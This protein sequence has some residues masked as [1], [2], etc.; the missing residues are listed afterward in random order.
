MRQPTIGIPVNNVTTETHSHTTWHPGERSMQAMAGMRERMDVI[1][2][3]ALRDFLPQQHRDFYAQLPFMVAG[4][5]DTADNPWATLLFGEPGFVSSPDA[6][7]LTLR[8]ATNTL[9]PATQHLRADSPIG[10][11]GIE[12]PTRRR[13]RVNGRL[14]HRDATGFG[15]QVEQTMGNC[16][17]YIQKRD[18]S[19]TPMANRPSAQTADVLP[20]T[21]RCVKNL[22]EAS[23][24]FFVASY[25]DVDGHR[26][27]DV[28][29][30]GGT[31]GFVQ[32]AVDGTLT[33]PDFTGNNFFNTLGNITLTGKAGLIFPDFSTRHVLQL[34]GRAALVLPTD[35]TGQ[36]PGAERYWR[37]HPTQILH[38]KHAM[39]LTWQLREA[40]PFHQSLGPWEHR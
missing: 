26:S 8:T 9:D 15:V 21:A 16:P 27:V 39:P 3:R 18:I 38:R 13:N 29:H 1:G 17:K 23:D 22:I 34:T 19:T 5:V 2:E 12:L 20:A 25:A 6:G 24:T 40:S 10:L 37:L 14:T 35:H 36:Y 30:R 32:V 33:V 28:S 4:T 11:L 31:P 7:Q